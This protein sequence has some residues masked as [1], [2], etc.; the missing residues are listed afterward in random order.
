VPIRT[1]FCSS[2]Y[3]LLG[4]KRLVWIRLE[5]VPKTRSENKINSIG[6]NSKKKL[7]TR[8]KEKTAQAALLEEGSLSELSLRFEGNAIDKGS[9]PGKCLDKKL[10]LELKDYGID[11]RLF[12]KTVYKNT[13]GNS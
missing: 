1:I 7:S 9:Y 6:K 10:Y 13:E 12:I 4:R 3:H 2:K 11:G 5:R 8:I